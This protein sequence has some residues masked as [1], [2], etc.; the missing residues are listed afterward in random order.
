M[1]RSLVVLTVAGSLSALMGCR[2]QTSDQPPIVPLRNMHKQQKYKMQEES[3]FFADHRTMRQLPEGALAQESY[4][5]STEEEHGL[6]EDGTGYVLTIPT[7]V[8]EKG[9]GIPSLARRGQDRYKIFCAPCHGGAGDGNGTVPARAT[10]LRTPW[11]VADLHDERLRHIPDGQLFVTISNGVRSM[12]GYAAQ[13]PVQDRWAIV[14]YVRA[15]QITQA[16][17]VGGGL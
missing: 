9:G 14:A 13:I 7:T 17:S 3:A 5:E 10:E 2:G 1:R 12:P 6:L 15:L 11:K 16:Q 4:F 8:T